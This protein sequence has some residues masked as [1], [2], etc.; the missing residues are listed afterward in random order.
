MSI[1]PNFYEGLHGEESY[2]SASFKVDRLISSGA[3]RSWQRNRENRPLRLL[4]VGCGKGRFLLDLTEQLKS[5]GLSISRVAAVD[6]VRAS[7]NFHSQVSPQIEFVQQSVDGVPLPF[8]DACFDLVSCNHVLEHVFRT[9]ALVRE[10]RR[11][12]VPS[13]FCVIGVPN[14][15]AW[16]NRIAF[17]FGGQPL[18]SEVGAE[19]T[20][21]GFWPTFLQGRLKRFVPSGH[22]RDF[23][24]RS[25]K[26]LSCACGFKHVGWW[27]QNG[28]AIARLNPKLVRDL[29]ILLEPAVRE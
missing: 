13:G 21:Y 19:A 2:G 3:F 25:I 27:A 28:E 18:G 11:V 15:A 23:T 26:D 22:I 12:L 17:L 20:T 14:V 8:S 6:I 7:P 5:G 4:D 16:M 1:D 24:P 9:E 10:F 29:A